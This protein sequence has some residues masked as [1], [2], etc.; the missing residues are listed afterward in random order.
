[1]RFSLKHAVSTALVLVPASLLPVATALSITLLNGYVAERL[2][3][4]IRATR[5]EDNA[6]GEAFLAWDTLAGHVPQSQ[7]DADLGAG[8]RLIAQDIAGLRQDGV[9]SSLVAEFQRTTDSYNSAIV[10]GVGQ[11]ASGNID[12]L[13]GQS[14]P[15]LAGYRQINTLVSSAQAEFRADAARAQTAQLWGGTGVIVLA[16]LLLAWLLVRSARRHRRSAVL[17]AEADALRQSEESFRMLFETNPHPM[18]VW[19]M[20]TRRH[21][22]AN[23]AAV[24]LYGYTGD[25]FLAMP[26]VDLQPLEDREG[27]LKRLEHVEPG[28]PFRGRARHLLK[29]GRIIHV[30]ITGRH[31]DFNGRPAFIALAQDLTERMALEEELRHQALYDSLTQLANRT[32]FRDRVEHALVSNARSF[33][34][35]AVLLLDLDRFK[36]VNDTLG[37]SA[38]DEVLVGV[39]D[40]IRGIVRPGDT[41]AHIGGDE[42]A[43]LL[44]GTDGAHAAAIA[45]RILDSLRAPFDTA[46]AAVFTSA[47]IGIAVCAGIDGYLGEEATIDGL[48]GRADVA[49]YAAKSEGRGRLQAYEPAMHR[50]ALHRME[51]GGELRRAVERGEFAV[52]YQ[53]VV[54]LDDGTITGLEALVRWRHPERGVVA[55]AD[56]VTAAEETGL[57]VPIGAWVLETACR[58]G[59]TW[60]SGGSEGL[61]PF[62]S[63]N[64]S[65]RQLC[66]PGFAETVRRTLEVTG[67]DP[68]RLILEV[69]E[70]ALVDDIHGVREQLEQLRGCGVRIAMDDFG[71]GYSSLGY[72]RGLPLDI[73]KIDR[74]FVAGLG[75]SR[76]D[77]ALTLAIVRL[78]GTI[79]AHIVAEGIETAEQLAYVRALGVEAGQGYYFSRPVAPAAAGLLIDGPGFCVALPEE[80]VPAR[81]RWTG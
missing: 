3:A 23:A 66:E 68:R 9:G 41:P 47:S 20:S 7:L 64:V 1:M 37:H 28:V 55:P 48:L 40:R 36:V 13:T 4:S 10:V 50:A 35:V 5:I 70:S 60:H 61:G 71:A 79:E 45:E 51:L 44:P 25:E 2:D 81:L 24:E 31:Q 14:L 38:G 77:R 74:M 46:G 52:E 39:A 75:T 78:L 15:V 34:P 26:I 56:F 49:M 62:I 11:L 42:F 33:T 32:L 76:D 16:S 43:V 59:Q 58:Q 67:L 27:G 80:T 65:S 72:L 21:L 22:A 19:D 29:D 53:P 12:L 57:I 30:E 8:R 73:V 54:A 69:T 63:V 6:T 17:R 18:W